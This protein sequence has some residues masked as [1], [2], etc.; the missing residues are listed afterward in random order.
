[1]LEGLSYTVLTAGNGK[2]ALQLFQNRHTDID[3]IL[4]DVVMPELSG[5]ALVRQL[6]EQ[7]YD[8]RAVLM[9][10]HPGEEISQRGPEPENCALLGKPFSLKQLAAAVREGL[11]N[12][13]PL[14]A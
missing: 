14:A 3:L 10:G 5:P 7:G 12:R 1:M 6:R 9:S 4:S 8:V 2:E 11:D 13:K